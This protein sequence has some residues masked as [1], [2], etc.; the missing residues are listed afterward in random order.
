MSRVGCVGLFAIIALGAALPGRAD[1]PILVQVVAVGQAAPGGGTFEHFGVASQPIVA[2]INARGQVAFFAGVLRGRA[3]EAF[4]LARGSR[5]VRIAA[6]GDAAPGG[7]TLSGFARHPVPALNNSGVVAFA[8]AISGG[9]GVEGIFI[10]RNGRVQI[11]AV[12]GMP[13]P[14]IASGTLAGVDAPA[15]NNRGDVVFLAT[16]RRGRETTEA[17]YLA[18]GRTLRK[19]VAQNDPAPAGGTFAG[20][21][22]PAVNDRGAIVFAAV[23]DGPAVPGGLFISEAHRTRML[24]GA[25]DDTPIGGIFAKFSE[26]LAL[27]E[28]GA[29]AFTAAL[30]NAPSREAIFVIDGTALRKVVAIGDTAPD[31]GS[32]AHF[33]PWPALGGDGSVAFAASLDG[34]RTDIGLFVATGSRMTPIASLGDSF[35]GA[36]RFTSFGLYPV[37]SMASTGAVTFSTT[38]TAA[39]QGV[40]AIFSAAPLVR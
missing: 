28:A 32:F 1:A 24:V 25:G 39:G 4:F 20:F 5:I 35:R 13:A 11:V 3:A 18:S 17:I 21:G 16:V 38:L 23:V 27:N 40:E 30:A 10:A 12:A 33:G 36:G 26:R 8:A 31:A 7:G 15:L 14:G 19:V 2:P 34:G 6:E 37:V 9:R 22:P 29:V